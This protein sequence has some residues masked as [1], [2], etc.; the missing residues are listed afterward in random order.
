MLLNEIIPKIIAPQLSER[1]IFEFSIFLYG[2]YDEFC[3]GIRVLDD[4]LYQF[5][6]DDMLDIPYNSISYKRNS[7]FTLF[8]Y[9]DKLYQKKIDVE[10]INGQVTHYL[11]S[12]SHKPTRI[13]YWHFQLYTKDNE[14]NYIPRGK[15]NSRL[16]H[17]AK[18]ILEQYVIKAICLKSDIK[19]FQLSNTSTDFKV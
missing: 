18:H 12:F 6:T 7:L 19:K 5:W 14:G 17:L 3:V 16:K 13:N 2:Y 4:S 1:E 11:L 9:T 10:D 8:L 15:S